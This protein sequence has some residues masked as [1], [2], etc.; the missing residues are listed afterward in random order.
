MASDDDMIFN[1]SMG[2]LL[3]SFEY[4]FV[5]ESTI[6]IKDSDVNITNNTRDWIMASNNIDLF[7]APANG[8]NCTSTT[9]SVAPY[10]DTVHVIQIIFASII[11]LAATANVTLHLIIKEL[12]TVS[13]VLIVSLCSFMILLNSAVLVYLLIDQGNG[14]VCAAF[15]YTFVVIYFIYDASKLSAL[16]QFVYLMYK[17]CKTHSV[18]S[19]NQKS[20]LYKFAV[21]IFLLS[22]ICSLSFILVDILV[23]KTNFKTTHGRC[24]YTV[25]P[26]NYGSV[27]TTLL[28]VQ[29]S[30][31]DVIKVSLMIAGLV[32]YFLTTRQCCSRVTRDVKLSIVPNCTVGINTGIVALLYFL[33]VSADINY[34]ITTIGTLIEQILL[35]VVFSTSNKVLSHCC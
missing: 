32:F 11:L 15:L 9:S 30:I 21:L 4:C 3:T 6:R 23:A 10:S 34:A 22:A 24:I 25:D 26:S 5:N 31:L 29:L 19:S 14:N 20:I 33:Q 16:I 1:S 28:L 17:S 13:G 35:F 18:T 12:Q 7:M 2:V 27:S 8:T